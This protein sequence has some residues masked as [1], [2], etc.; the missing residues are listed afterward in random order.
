MGLIKS[1]NKNFK[2]ITKNAKTINPVKHAKNSFKIST[3]AGK[4]TVDWFSG[5]PVGTSG[6]LEVGLLAPELA[7]LTAL[8]IPPTKDVQLSLRGSQVMTPPTAS[9][10]ALDVG[11][12]GYMP[13]VNPEFQYFTNPP[14]PA[15]APAPAVVAPVDQ[16][17]GSIYAQYGITPMGYGNY[18]IPA[19]EMPNSPMLFSAGGHTS[20]NPYSG[21]S[22]S[23]VPNALMK[24]APEFYA[25]GGQV[26]PM[27]QGG[28][29]ED[30]VQLTAAAILG[31][32]ENGDQIIQE[33]ISQYGPEAFA[34]LRDQVL[35]E[36]VP[37]AQTEGMVQGEG[38]GQDDTVRGMIGNQR[39]VAISPGEYIVPA[40]AVALAGGGYSGDGAKFFDNLIEDIRRKTTGNPQQARPY[41]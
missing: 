20:I 36:V 29:G 10:S 33:F 2:K 14:E 8:G 31:E 6:D 35:K 17:V 16:G 23:S 15:P 18:Q 9:Y 11:G 12:A 13:G 27:G 38:G 40:D 21:R 37:G 25:D 24:V 34:M 4:D 5:K 28:Q 19:S 22:Y 39:P 41:R 1:M 26:A 30:L 32:V 7:D 3:S